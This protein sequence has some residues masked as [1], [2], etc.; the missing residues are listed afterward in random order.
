MKYLISLYFDEH[1][2]R[3][4]YKYME[5]VTEAT[6]N[7]YM[8]V[9]GVP[10]HITVASFET[11]NV[12]TVINTLEPCFKSM[13]KGEISWV[14]TGAFMTSVLYLNSVLNE[15]LQKIVLEVYGCITAI[16]DIRISKYYQPNQWLPHTTIGK[17]MTKEELVRGFQAV[18]GD[19][20]VLLGHSVKVGLAQA[21][22]YEDIMVWEF[23]N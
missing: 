12:E 5:A 3:Q 9:H 1:T 21:S 22:P 20:K 15:Y 17:K 19:F 6:G 18:Q 14:G 23:I 11:E 4:I 10:P 16:P 7:D 2:N 8:F 13:Q